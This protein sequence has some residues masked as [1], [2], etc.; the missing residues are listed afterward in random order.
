MIS[1]ALVDSL[2]EAPGTVGFRPHEGR[3]QTRERAGGHAVQAPDP[4]VGVIGDRDRP[5]VPANR[6]RSG[7]VAGVDRD[8]RVLRTT[9]LQLMSRA[10]GDHVY[11]PDGPHAALRNAVMSAKSQPQWHE[12][13]DWLYGGNGLD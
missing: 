7:R 5:A 1:A 6:L 3:Q 10:M 13:L 4:S 8:R 12:T 2:F 11:H 9:R